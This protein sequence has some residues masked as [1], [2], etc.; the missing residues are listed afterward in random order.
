[1]RLLPHESWSGV[2]DSR[3]V[4]RVKAVGLAGD[5]FDDNEINPPM[6][7]DSAAA[8]WEW[9]EKG[10]SAP[11]EGSAKPVPT[12]PTVVYRGQA[13]ASH[14]LSSSLY[15]LCRHEKG[16]TVAEADLAATETAIIKGM[17]AEGLGRLMTDGELLMVLQHHGI[18]TRLID[19]STAAREALFFAVDHNDAADGRLFIIEVH[20]R[21]PLRLE[22]DQELPWTDAV[23][24][25][26]STAEWSGTVA[27]VDAAP[28]DPRM[29]AQRGK[30]LVGGLNRRL[31]GR[32][33]RIGGSKLAAVDFPEVTSLGINFV[34]QR[35]A[36]RLRNKNWPATGWTIGINAAWKPELRDRLEECTDSIRLDTM[37]PPVTEVKRLALSLARQSL[38]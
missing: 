27:L 14:G 19:V 3:A 18:P 10:A 21:D 34:E 24:G 7:I 15:R 37:Y 13:T 12:G 32:F 1:M 4:D 17:R 36:R 35:R 9:M 20:R 29:R 33:M 31:S 22:A 2:G 5:F 25:T 6:R 26:R 16:T 23:W 11:L 28:L 30:F 8:L 38:T